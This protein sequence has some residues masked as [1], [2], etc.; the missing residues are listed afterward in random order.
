MFQYKYREIKRGEE[1][2]EFSLCMIPVCINFND[3]G[4]GH[5][6]PNNAVQISVSTNYKL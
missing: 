2:R 5:Q 4:L 1:E 6:Y 3:C